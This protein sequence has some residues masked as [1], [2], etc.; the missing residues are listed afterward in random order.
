MPGVWI[1]QTFAGFDM[2]AFEALGNLQCDTL[3]L[4]AKIF[5]SM[6]AVPYI[7]LIALMGLIMCFFKKT[8]KI[9]FALMFSVIIGTLVTNILVKPMVGRLRPYVTLAENSQFMSWYRAAGALTE[10]DKCFPSGHT[11][12]AM[13]IATALL[14]CHATSKKKGA[15]AVC[16]IFPLIA[17]AVAASRVYLMV[18]Y[19]TDV[20]AAMVVGVFAG[21]F[22]FLLSK[23]ACAI[24]NTS[25]EQRQLAAGEHL[26]GGVRFMIAL[27]WLVA[28]GVAFL[29]IMLQ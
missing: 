9:G 23:A 15:R 10:S 20:L 22:G 11:T 18:H 1:D 26:R 3:T 19:A 14:L 28:F 29:Y 4:I 12:G 5:T 21:I 25:K 24:F 27:G 8:R 6:G 7:I 16:W 13:E 2:A 17:I